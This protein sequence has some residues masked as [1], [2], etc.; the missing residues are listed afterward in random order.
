LREDF[1]I[2]P[3]SSLRQQVRQEPGQ[4]VL[5]QEFPQVQRWVQQERRR[6]QQERRRVQQFQ[7]PFGRRRSMQEPAGRQ[8]VRYVSFCVPW[9]VEVEKH[10]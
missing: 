6:V 2:T 7:Q 1:W 3:S 10:E 5:Q 8:Q 9:E 4:Q